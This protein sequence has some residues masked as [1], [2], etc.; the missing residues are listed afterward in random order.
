MN[1]PF[2]FLNTFVQSYTFS[3]KYLFNCI[4]K[5]GNAVFI[6]IQ[7]KIVSD[8]HGDSCLSQV[9]LGMCCLIFKCLL[10]F[11]CLSAIDI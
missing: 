3:S 1:Q 8:L 7:L 10:I 5:I 4:P 9:Y 2:L 11:F 6:I